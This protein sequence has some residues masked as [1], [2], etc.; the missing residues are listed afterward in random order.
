MKK[1]LFLLTFALIGHTPAIAAPIY[2]FPV[3][4]CKATYGKYHHDY[5][6]TDIKQRSVVLLLRRLMALLK[7]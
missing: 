3:A 2:V 1:F 4:N 7:M 6:A 5:P